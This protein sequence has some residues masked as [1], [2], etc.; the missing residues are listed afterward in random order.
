MGSFTLEMLIW[1]LIPK[2][3]D[4]TSWLQRH[5]AR[6]VLPR[7]FPGPERH[8]DRAYRGRRRWLTAAASYIYKISRCLEGFTLRDLV[9]T[10]LLRF[11][12]V[13]N[14]TWLAYLVCAQTFG[15]DQNCDCLSSNWGPNYNESGH[16]AELSPPGVQYYW[17]FGVGL[18]VTIMIGAIAYITYQY[19]TQSHLSSE[20]YAQAMQGLR[21]TR[22]FKRRTIW[23]RYVL[24]AI[25]RTFKQILH[26]LFGTKAKSVRRSLVWTPNAEESTPSTAEASDETLRQ[27][28]SPASK[29]AS[30]EHVERSSVSDRHIH[31]SSSRDD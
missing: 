2:A 31:P 28:P 10:T 6:V 19:C 17:G 27:Q 8:L 5:G 23:T 25:I 21:T 13:V 18:S 20:D 14:S 16:E 22:W 1:W 7:Y 24:E 9:E 30:V 4:T 26:R 29:P 11:C 15:A 3:E 12:D